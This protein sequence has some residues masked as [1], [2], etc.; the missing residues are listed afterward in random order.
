MADYPPAPVMEGH[1]LAYQKNANTPTSNW[2]VEKV[3]AFNI[4]RASLKTLCSEFE[5]C[6]TRFV[7]GIL[8]Q[9]QRAIRRSN[10]HAILVLGMC[11]LSNRSQSDLDQPH[12]RT[13]H[14]L[15]ALELPG[16]PSVILVNLRTDCIRFEEKSSEKSYDGEHC[17]P[18]TQTEFKL[19]IELVAKEI[20]VAKDVFGIKFCSVFSFSRE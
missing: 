7:R 19:C 20:S 9:I 17:M 11:H 18:I 1:G 16:G 3:K 6:G 13:E 10:G 8:P 12:C 5:E 4:N 14:I 2:T 15:Q